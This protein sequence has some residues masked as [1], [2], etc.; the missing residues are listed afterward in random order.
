[1]IT[2]TL[3]RVPYQEAWHL[4]RELQRAV[5]A[6]EKPE[7]L[8]LC[9]HPPTITIGKSS[10]EGH[11][12]AGAEQLKA[13]GVET[14][15]VERGGDVTFHGPGQLV[16]YP[17]LD[18]RKRRRD[19]GWYM[20]QL[21]EVLIRLLK[22]YELEGTR[23]QGK[24]GVWLAANAHCPHPRKLASLG[25]RISRWV[26][27]HGF[28]LNVGS[29]PGELSLERGF[30]L[31]KPCGLGDVDMSSIARELHEKENCRSPH[32]PANKGSIRALAVE[33]LLPALQKHFVDVFPPCE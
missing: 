14:F 24:T 31:I 26:T 32:A 2:R 12:L 21:E 28:A 23:V 7:H 16:G 1:M 15:E 3:G 33:E 8:L 11:I 10:G 13:L 27:M 22:E 18:L 20:R 6:E 19:V 29:V 30:S 17:I 4:Q 9:E 25:V 5:I